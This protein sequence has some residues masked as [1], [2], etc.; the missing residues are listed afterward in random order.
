MPIFALGPRTFFRR[1]KNLPLGRSES[2]IYLGFS[3]AT[4]YNTISF[5]PLS[6]VV[7]PIIYLLA[8]VTRV[9]LTN[10]DSSGLSIDRFREGR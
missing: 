9:L 7:P 8:L 3:L 4:K 1:A 2:T 6:L 5:P 10:R